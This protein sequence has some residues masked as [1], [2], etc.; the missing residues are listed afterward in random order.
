MK[1]C[2]NEDSTTLKYPPW[3]RVSGGPKI[4][5]S[6]SN[7][8]SSVKSLTRKPSIGSSWILLY[9][10]C[11]ARTALVDDDDPLIFTLVPRRL[12]RSWVESKEWHTKVGR[13]QTR[14]ECQVLS[15]YTLNR[16]TWHVKSHAFLKKIQDILQNNFRLIGFLARSL[17]LE[18]L[19][20][21]KIF[22][23]MQNKMTHSDW[24]MLYW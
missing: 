23:Y 14:S 24:S 22:C 12:T 2:K 16:I 19:F 18:C 10:S 3:Y 1:T 7:K 17:D 20:K 8:L 15:Q 5:T 21:S 6:Q 9:S 11:R 4:A 13:K